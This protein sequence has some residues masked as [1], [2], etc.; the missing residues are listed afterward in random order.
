MDINKPCK[1]HIFVT[2]AKF[3]ANV[4][5]RPN[6]IFKTINL[7]D[8]PHKRKYK[9]KARSK[10][11]KKTQITQNSARSRNTQNCLLSLQT[12]PNA[13]MSRTLRNLLV[14][15]QTPNCHMTP[16]ASRNLLWDQSFSALYRTDHENN[17][18][19]Q[20]LEEYYEMHKPK[21]F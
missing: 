7:E 12:T 13:F 19:K 18:I 20:R 21:Y 9:R 10:S 3:L 6:N 15:P 14:T 8:L 1:K 4:P 16:S 5:R 11:N 2:Q 17:V